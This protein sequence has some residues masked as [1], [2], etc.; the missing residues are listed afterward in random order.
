MSPY[1]AFRAALSTYL[2]TGQWD[3]PETRTYLALERETDWEERKAALD[4]EQAADVGV[5][6]CPICGVTH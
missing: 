1:I 4:R 3:T 2:A 6:R 5:H